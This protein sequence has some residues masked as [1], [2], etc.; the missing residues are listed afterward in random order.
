MAKNGPKGGGRKGAIRGRTQFKNP[1]TG[2]YTKRD[3]NTGKFL[4]NKADGERFK[5]VRRER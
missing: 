3:A 4:D 1:A 2:T 5:G